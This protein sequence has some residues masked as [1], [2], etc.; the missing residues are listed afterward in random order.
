MKSSRTFEVEL[1]CGNSQSVKA[2]DYFRRRASSLIFDGILNA[3]LSNSKRLTRSFSPL[4]L[5]KGIADFSC[6]LILLIYTNN[7]KN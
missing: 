4:G 7:K 2:V 6:L 5:R 1:F 3:T